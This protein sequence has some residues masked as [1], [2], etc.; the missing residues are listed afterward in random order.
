MLNKAYKTGKC[1]YNITMSIKKLN[2]YHN[3]RKY[4]YIY[5]TIKIEK[6]K[7][8]FIKIYTCFSWTI[9]EMML[10]KKE[11]FLR[12]YKKLSKNVVEK[13]IINEIK[14][15]NISKNDK[16]LHIGCGPFPSTALY[17]K[18]FTNARIVTIDKRFLAVKLAK[19][20]I[21][22]KKIKDIDIFHAAGESFP[23]NGFDIVIITSCVTPIEKVLKNIFENSNKNCKVICRELKYIKNTPKTYLQ[24]NNCYI[25]KKISHLDWS[26][27][28]I[29]KTA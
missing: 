2:T 13:S 5:L 15:A 11:F 18:K 20:Y 10:V 9:L 7:E 23:M 4:K 27:Y 21:T 8:K 17:L 14:M 25:V 12:F 1:I 3:I 16:I 22:N 26:S 19:K 29:K 24:N 28:L 6:V